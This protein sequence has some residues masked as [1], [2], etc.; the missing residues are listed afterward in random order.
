MQLAD[1]TT[2]KNDSNNLSSFQNQQ[3]SLK[4]DFLDFVILEKNSSPIGPFDD[5][6]FWDCDKNRLSER[7]RKMV[8]LCECVSV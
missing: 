2:S 3:K 4:K 8:P 7:I 6:V 5:K 1:G